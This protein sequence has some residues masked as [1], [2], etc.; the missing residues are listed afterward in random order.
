M[1]QLVNEEIRKLS[2]QGI[3][4]RELARAQNT[5][6][7]QFL[8]QL[9]H[10]GTPWGEPVLPPIPIGTTVL[11]WPGFLAFS[12][13]FRD[14]FPDG[15]H[16]FSFVIAE[17]DSVA[18]IVVIFEFD[19]NLIEAAQ[20]IR[21]SIASVRDKLPALRQ[22]QFSLLAPPPPAAAGDSLRTAPAAP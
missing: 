13:A 1:A 7:A 19:K 8:D 17:G 2:A 6:R 20:E 16:V 21:D 5:Y 3:T 12:E 4:D 14:G 15:K 9:R 18:T 10:T 11:D 22:Y